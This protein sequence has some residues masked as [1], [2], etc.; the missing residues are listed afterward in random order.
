M[1]EESPLRLFLL[2]RSEHAAAIPAQSQRPASLRA[3]CLGRSSMAIQGFGRWLFALRMALS[4]LKEKRPQGMTEFQKMGLP[5][6]K[7]ENPFVCRSMKILYGESRK[8]CMPK[9]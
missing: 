5:H 6:E 8:F 3:F 2:G 7:L 1:G 4:A 9:R